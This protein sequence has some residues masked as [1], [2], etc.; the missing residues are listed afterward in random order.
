MTDDKPPRIV[1][2]GLPLLFSL[3]LV[4]LYYMT[5]HGFAG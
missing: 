4:V 3:A 1:K 2:L 5:H